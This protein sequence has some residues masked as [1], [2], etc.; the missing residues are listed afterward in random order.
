M[1]VQWRTQ[2][3]I[4]KKRDRGEADRVF[5]VFTKE[6]GKLQLWA[7]SCRKITSKLRS[8]LEMPY[9]S[10]FAFVQGK[11]KKTVVDALPLE[12]YAGIR[13]DLPKLK[14]S[15]RMLATLDFFLKGE[16]QDEKVWELLRQCLHAL[17]ENTTH[18]NNCSRVY[19][20]FFWNLVSLLGWEPS[21][22]KLG[23]DAQKPLQALRTLPLAEVMDVPEKEFIVEVLHK[24]TKEYF[25]RVI[26]EVQ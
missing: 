13:E 7:V 17:N 24:A 15:F 8:G 18:A 22:A 10:D 3:I 9:C 26:K 2:G 21:H 5:T 19:Y 4:L 16:S 12:T 11:T 14:V 1:S 20:Y 6:Y 23:K 25:S